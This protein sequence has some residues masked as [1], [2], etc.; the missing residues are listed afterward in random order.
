MKTTR[1]TLCHR[2][3]GHKYYFDQRGRDPSDPLAVKDY[4]SEVRAA[5]GT[6]R[7]VVIASAAPGTGFSLRG[8]G[9][10]CYWAR[11]SADACITRYSPRT[12]KATV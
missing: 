6:L 2:C 8:C 12:G 4:A 9:T 10:D 5:Y 7:G 11:E 1:M 3:D